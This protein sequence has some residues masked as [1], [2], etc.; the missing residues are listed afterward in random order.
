MTKSIPTPKLQTSNPS[1]RPLDHSSA[2]AS[3]SK[4]SWKPTSKVVSRPTPTL[5]VS[6]PALRVVPKAAAKPAAK[7]ASKSV[8]KKSIVVAPPSS[9]GSLCDILS[10]LGDSYVAY[11]EALV[12]EGYDTLEELRHVEL[13]DLLEVGMKKGHAKRLLKYIE[14]K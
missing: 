3:S 4:P 8:V 11:E 14:S 9:S 5:P 12:E 6:K 1:S 2:V 10:N 13:D 7:L